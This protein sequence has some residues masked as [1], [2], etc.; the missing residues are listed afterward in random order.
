V[1]H[2]LSRMGRMGISWL[3]LKTQRPVDL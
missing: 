2:D 1:G 3:E